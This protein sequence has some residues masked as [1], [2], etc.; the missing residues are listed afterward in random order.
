MDEEREQQRA[1]FPL[2]AGDAVRIEKADGYLLIECFR[3]RSAEAIHFSNGDDKLLILGYDRESVQIAH[4][5]AETSGLTIG[6][7]ETVA[8]NI[9]RFKLIAR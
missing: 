7:V 8:P 4:L 6:G 3:S 2:Q 1:T 9:Q 5:V